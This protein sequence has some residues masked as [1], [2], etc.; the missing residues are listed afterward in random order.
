[1][2]QAL[3]NISGKVQGVS[4]RYNA[5]R[6]AEDFGL[7]GYAENLSNG[8]VEALIQG[9]ESLIKQFIDWCKEGPSNA[10][11]DQVYT[12]WQDVTDIYDSFEVL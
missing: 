5:F 7:K 1:M 2:K 8:N 3:L 10:K 11:V 6:K 9:E 4:F 12:V